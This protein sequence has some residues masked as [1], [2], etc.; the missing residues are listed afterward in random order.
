MKL[1]LKQTLIT[2]AVILLSVSLCLYFFVAKET[3]GLIRRQSRTES[4]IRRYSAIICPPW[5]AH[6]PR[7]MMRTASPGSR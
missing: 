7:P 3:D 4:G 1:W 2:L 6:L 5:I